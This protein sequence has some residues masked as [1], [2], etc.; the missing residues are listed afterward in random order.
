MKGLSLWLC[1]YK[2]NISI[3]KLEL[4]INIRVVSS[5]EE[6]TTCIRQCAMAH[7]LERKIIFVD[8]YQ[9]I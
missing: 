7:L 3:F 5:A 2:R 4:E 8:V 9:S 6:F 1:D